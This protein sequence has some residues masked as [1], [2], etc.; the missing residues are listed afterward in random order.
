MRANLGAL[1][2][3]AAEL[4][5]RL[6]QVDDGF[7]VAWGDWDTPPKIKGFK[8]MRG[9]SDDIRSAGFE[10]GVWLAPAAADKH[11]QLVKDHPDWVLR[12]KWGRPVNCGFCG[13]FYIGLD[14]SHPEALK[15]AVR[16]VRIRAATHRFA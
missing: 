16:T 13:K 8:D 1:Q 2:D 15:H 14:M 4:P 11:S 3:G 12:D 10:P 7:S 6:V 9:L 5:L